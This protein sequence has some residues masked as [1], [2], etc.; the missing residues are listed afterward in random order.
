CSRSGGG[1]SS[2]PPRGRMASPARMPD[3]RGDDARPD[4]A[5]QMA[6]RWDMTFAVAAPAPAVASAD[7]E[8]LEYMQRTCYCRLC[9]GVMSNWLHG[10]TGIKREWPLPPTEN[11]ANR[12]S[13]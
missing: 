13:R 7:S 10:L 8:T 4:R 9:A 3:D 1:V 6:K 11:R 5:R 12:H 2:K